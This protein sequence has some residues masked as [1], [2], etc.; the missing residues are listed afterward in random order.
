MQDD[1]LIQKSLQGDDE[2]FGELVKKYSPNV[3]QHCFSMVKDVEIAQDLTQETFLR[4]F[5]NLGSFHHRARF[6][7]W[8]WRIAHNVTLNYLKK[9]RPTEEKFIE[10]IMGEKTEDREKLVD[11]TEEL[12]RLSPKH[13]LVM[14]MYYQEN[15]SQKEIAAKLN[16]PCGTVRS[17]LHY[18]RGRIKISSKSFK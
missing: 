3:F 17:R 10:E 13:R 11:M 5:K 14:Q 9:K 15:L 7:T 12:N 1:E 4:I 8:I 16:I 18:A 6:S 2:A